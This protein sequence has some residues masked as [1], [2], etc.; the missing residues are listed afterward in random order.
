VKKI[1]LTSIEH[2]VDLPSGS[3][4]LVW[5]E[6]RFLAAAGH[7]VWAVA[8]CADRSAPEREVRDDVHLLRYTPPRSSA[9]DPRRRQMHQQATQNVIKRC[10]GG[11]IQFVHGHSPLQ[12]E[13][14][15][16]VTSPNACKVY[17][18][19]SPAAMELTA[20]A[21]TESWPGKLQSKMA[22]SAINRVERRCLRRAHRVTALSEFTVNCLRELHGDGLADKVRVCPGW[23]DVDR[24][25]VVNDRDMAKRQLGWPTD[26]PVL[27][28]LRRLVPRMGLD[29][30]L[31]AMA[32]L[33]AKSI[34]PYLVIG[35]TGPMRGA[36]EQLRD[37]LGLGSTVQF[38]GRV[39]DGILP[40]LYGACDA[41]VLPT[42]ELECFGLIALEALA[43]G[44]P[45]LAT[46]VGAL[47]EVVRHVEPNWLAKDTTAE[48]IANL[49]WTFI[50][51][52]LP[53]YSPETLRSKIAAEFNAS[54]RLQD[55]VV[56]I[57]D[58]NTN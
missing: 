6:A 54:R 26:I 33:K 20:A 11:E 19:H 50:Q 28:T 34:P 22:S 58:L 9:F 38:A 48:A 32:I 23:V 27:F 44:R 43:C 29:R 4:R 51:G 2:Y 24:F 15:L 47:P 18:V 57:V 30:L 25:R 14:A 37:D 10:I 46:P 55:L 39:D 13:G 53:Q 21:A 1:L 8:A 41:F 42:A 12:F 52:A 16:Q 3:A 36:L 35:G 17:T 56:T 49:I 7:E 45:V 5:D 31:H 40:V